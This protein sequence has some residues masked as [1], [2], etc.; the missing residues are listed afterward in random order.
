MS[1]TIDCSAALEHDGASGVDLPAS[2]KLLAGRSITLTQGQ[3]AFDA[4]QQ[5]CA[6]SGI[7]IST[8]GSG[9]SVYVQ[10]I[11]GLAEKM[12][13]GA[14]GWLYYVNGSYIP[15]SCGAYQASAEDSILFV[16]TTGR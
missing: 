1:V 9:K 16:Y 4:L 3:T 13:G 2:G 11:G 6:Q 7:A 15:K 14:S 12:C 5:A 10:S 8:S